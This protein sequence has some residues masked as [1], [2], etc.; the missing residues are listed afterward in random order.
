MLP[1]NPKP[2]LSQEDVE[3]RILRYLQTKDVW[4]QT[5]EMWMD[6]TATMVKYLIGP[7]LES[8][9]FAGLIEADQQFQRYRIRVAKPASPKLCRCGGYEHPGFPCPEP[10]RQMMV[11]LEAESV[12][13]GRVR[14]VPVRVPIILNGVTYLVD[15]AVRD[16]LVQLSD[17]VGTLE[18]EHE[19][20]LRRIRNLAM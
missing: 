17:R 19:E 9:L 4:V 12:P 11:Q 14:A 5:E 10:P 15:P 3:T 6:L 1:N 7:A 18:A 13:I 2:S 8:L 16:C 20:L